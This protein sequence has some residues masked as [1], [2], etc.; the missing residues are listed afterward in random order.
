MLRRQRLRGL[1]AHR[2]A[3]GSR[4]RHG[5]PGRLRSGRLRSRALHRLRLRHGHR[6][7]RAA[8]CT[9]STTSACSTRTTC[10]SSSSSRCEGPRLL[11]ARFVDVPVGTEALGRAAAPGRL[12]ARLDRAASIRWSA[13]PGR[14]PVR[15]R[16]S[17]SRSPPTGPT[18]SASPASRAKWRRSTMCRCASGRRPLPPASTPSAV[19]P[20][21]VT[22]EDPAL[23]PRYA[24][25]LA[26]VTVGPS[27]AWLAGRLPLRR[28][29]HQQ[30]RRH[31]QLRAAR[32]RPADPRLR[33]GA[34]RADRAARP[35]GA[36]P[37]ET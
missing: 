16:S 2:L 4:L 15:T 30:H 12:R 19:G 27:P 33:F 22:I 3:R 18:A 34:A 11:A 23:C 28:P 35:P 37:G 13:R 7:P 25:A 24:A 20:L 17:T 32:D 9:A 26:D 31:H 36:P 8:A 6:A 5:P 21:R 1:Q 10:G 14:R 29:P